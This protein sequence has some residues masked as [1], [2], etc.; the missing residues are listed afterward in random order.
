MATR[1][2]ELEQKVSDL[3]YR[4]EEL[5][6]ANRIPPHFAVIESVADLN[7]MVAHPHGTFKL[8]ANLNLTN[9]TPL[10]NAATPFTGEFFAPVDSNGNPEFVINN[11]TINS[12]SYSRGIYYAALIGHSTGTIS[13]IVINNLTINVDISSPTIETATVLASGLVGENTGSIKNSRVNN[14]NINVEVAAQVSVEAAGIAARHMGENA[15]IINA[16]SANGS[17]NIN[18]LSSNSRAGGVVST[19]AASSITL[20]SSSVDINIS[21][22]STG[23]ST[24]GAGLVAYMYSGSILQSFATG[25]VT[26]LNTMPETVYAGGLVGNINSRALA[27]SSGRHYTSIVESFATGNVD[28]TS[29]GGKYVSPLI[30]RIDDRETAPSTILISSVYSTGNAQVNRT[31]PPLGNNVFVGGITSRIQAMS[32]SSITI[33]NAFV[34]G[35]LTG[36][37]GVPG[38]NDQ[39]VGAIVGRN[40][41]TGNAGTVFN[42]LFAYQNLEVVG[43]VHT[44][45]A[46]GI[47]FAHAAV[48]ATTEA[49]LLDATWQQENLGFNNDVWIFEDQSFPVLNLETLIMQA[50]GGVLING[51]R[52]SHAPGVFN[53]EFDL[54]VSAVGHPNATIYWT[55]D[56]REPV[57]EPAR[58]I[59]RHARANIQASGSFASGDTIAIEDR[60]GNWHEDTILTRY[61]A[62]RLHPFYQTGA[63]SNNATIPQGVSLMMRA[64]VN[65]VPVSE[66]IT[67][68]YLIWEN[69]A[70]QFNNIPI[71]AVT[72][73]SSTS[74][75]WAVYDDIRITTDQSVRRNFHYE[76][77]EPNANGSYSRI[78]NMVGSTQLGGVG[79][80]PL[81]QRTFN[82]HLARGDLEGHVDHP[83]FAGLYDLTRFRLWN[84]GSSFNRCFM[85]DPF[86]QK[87]AYLGDLDVIHADYRLALKF[88]NGEFWGFTTI[89]EHTSNNFF[90]YSRLGIT[91]RNNASIIDK[92]W[93]SANGRRMEV[94]ESAGGLT[95]IALAELEDFVFNNDLSLDINRAR[96]FAEFICES[97]FIDYLITN[98]FFNNLDWPSNN[99]RMVRAATADPTSDNKYMDGMW[100]FILHDMDGAALVTPDLG[101]YQPFGFGAP[102]DFNSFIRLT[103]RTHLST[104]RRDR[105]GPHLF[106]VINNPVFAQRV[107]DRGLEVL[108]TAFTAENLVEIFNNMYQG[109]RILLEEHFNRFTTTLDRTVESS[110]SNFYRYVDVLYS[111]IT[112]RQVYYK[113]HL[114]YLVDRF[115]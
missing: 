78:F 107:R 7:A 68:F 100:R 64:F 92:T 81:S 108:D 62:R 114:H 30:A 94:E 44:N 25:D 2:E 69:L 76:F 52:L 24:I 27:T 83:V 113:E 15:R 21:T 102:V 79:S 22:A 39:A 28:A 13:D 85:R 61:A 99:L 5:E 84:S 93:Y 56:G 90:T 41:H 40:Q 45:E 70:E 66:T 34:T 111:F 86:A 31:T 36:L 110:I 88:I 49:N 11:L 95:E 103:D 54:V 42:N 19:M 33:E 98:T 72:A 9:F 26:T 14:V 51:L 82:V 23:P 63:P 50:Q 43:G 71:I 60:T 59:A 115:N 8:G 105:F 87:A 96:L 112:N 37:L 109:R 4:I 91:P 16:T 65:G 32:G 104:H 77:F 57:A 67:T 55:I 3:E 101:E 73:N 10:F 53:E 17:I 38:S 18:S 48:T 80:R 12:P 106:T 58:F 29:E 74:E 97:N 47:H 35:N 46:Q 6:E 89:R 20:A 1:I 75:F